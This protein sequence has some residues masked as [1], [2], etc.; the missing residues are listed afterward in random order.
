MMATRTAR[1][2]RASTNAANASAHRPENIAIAV[3]TNLRAPGLNPRRPRGYCRCDRLA[4]ARPRAARRS[5]R[6]CAFEV[7]GGTVGRPGTVLPTSKAFR[8]HRARA[9][10]FAKLAHYPKSGS[11]ASGTC[12]GL[13]RLLRRRR[14][15]PGNTPR[16]FR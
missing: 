14:C 11:I 7:Y 9:G 5:I 8:K 2:C 12:S 10:A 15:S 3:C 4:S 6:T 16:A 1:S 13:R